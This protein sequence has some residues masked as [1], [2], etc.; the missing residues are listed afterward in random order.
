[1][2]YCPIGPYNKPF[3]TKFRASL[4]QPMPASGIPLRPFALAMKAVSAFAS[5]INIRAGSRGIRRGQVESPHGAIGPGS[6]RVGVTHANPF[7]PMARRPQ[8]GLLR[9]QTARQVF[10]RAALPVSDM[11]LGS[12]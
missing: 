1:M 12:A 4:T 2:L 9:P 3:V 8:V 7:A 11:V 10:D 6:A 5:E